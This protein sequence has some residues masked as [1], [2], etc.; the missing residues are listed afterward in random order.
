MK[1]IFVISAMVVVGLPA[2]A[3]DVVR[4]DAAQ[5]ARAG[6]V[7]RPVLER[8]FGDQQRVVGQV[9][10]SPGA[11]IHLKAVVGGR[12]ESLNVAPG[13][14]VRLGQV[15]AELHSHEILAM[16]GELLRA[17]E[18]AVLADKRLEAGKELFSVDGI[19]RIDLEV[20]E[21]E[22]FLAGL[23]LDTA[24]EELVD[25]GVP[26]AVLD[27]ILESRK[28]DAHLPIVAPA[29]GVVLELHV[30]RHEWVQDY[31]SLMVIGD[32]EKVELELQIAPDLAT[33]V[34]PGDL[35]EF[36][37]V[38]RP[39]GL[40]RATVVSR[41]PQVDPSSRTLRIR[42]RIIEH[43][44]GLF[45]GAFVEGTLTHGE[46]SQSPSVPESAVINVGGNDVVFVDG[47]GGAF[48]M[49]RVEL[50]LSNG[51]RYQV[52]HGVELG[53]QVA[54]EGVFFLKSALMKGGDGED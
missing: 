46:A 11:T 42:A 26:A 8:S 15:V 28:P 24:Y 12:V 33:S 31:A 18:R 17:A 32:P 6:L 22:A 51:N 30:Q 27:G 45:P 9:I 3:G 14:R 2:F 40:G 34:S 50:G 7:V 36:A 35:V 52:V 49:R 4:L 16:Q 48:E 53:E 23:D 38:G 44:S 41:V 20:R 43:G 54:V 5:Q 13:D 10:R 19:S 21:Q 29:D 25:H 1:S 39:A 37:A 47:G